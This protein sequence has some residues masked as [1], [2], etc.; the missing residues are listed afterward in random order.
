MLYKFGESGDHRLGF[1][2]WNVIDEPALPVV[3]PR[4]FELSLESKTESV[5]S[6]EEPSMLVRTVA[7]M[8][9]SADARRSMFVIYSLLET[10]SIETVCQIPLQGYRDQDQPEILKQ[11]R[12]HKVPYRKCGKAQHAAYQWEYCAR[13]HQWGRVRIK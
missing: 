6:E 11:G 4:M 9:P 1:S 5:T 12:N 3:V 8:V 10:D 13:Q 7:L 2:T